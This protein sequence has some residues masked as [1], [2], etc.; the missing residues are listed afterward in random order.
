MSNTPPNKHNI[1]LNFEQINKQQS[2]FNLV[3]NFGEA[4]PSINYLN[5]NISGSNTEILINR[6]QLNTKIDTRVDAEI[7][8]INWENVDNRGQVLAHIN[9]SV[10]SEILGINDINHILG[11]SIG[12]S[13]KFKKAI[14]CLSVVEIPWS[15]PI[16]RVSNEAL[17]YEQSL[18]LSNQADVR[19]EQA[20]SLNRVVRSMCEQ[21]TGLS[22]DAYLVWEEGDALYSSTLCT[23]GHDQITP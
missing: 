9:T 10:E 15:K 20:G 1:L 12:L 5:S 14:A 4:R 16:L 22:S 21:A 8:G 18:V 13:A 7:F 2:R 3:L 19:F 11:V 6:G 23:R 17:F